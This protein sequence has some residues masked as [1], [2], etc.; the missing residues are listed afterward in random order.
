MRPVSPIWRGVFPK[1]PDVDHELELGQ[2][3]QGARGRGDKLRIGR[4]KGIAVEHDQQRHARRPAAL[5]EPLERQLG[6]QLTGREPARPQHRTHAR[7]KRQTD[8]DRHEPCGDDHPPPPQD[9]AA[10]TLEQQTVSLLR[11]RLESS[12]DKLNRAKRVRDDVFA[13]I[14]TRNRSLTGVPAGYGATASSASTSSSSP[15]NPSKRDATRP[16]LSTTKTHGSLVSRH[17]L[18]VSV[19]TSLPSPRAVSITHGS[20]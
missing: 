9:E 19:S 14:R 20:T 2:R 10:K 5:L 17:S 15:R 7:R 4:T 1:R 3:M 8:R 18:A 6:F 16:S 13:S 12:T 11:N